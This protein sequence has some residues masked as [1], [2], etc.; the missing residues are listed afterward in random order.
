M[1]LRFVW[2]I[3]VALI[4]AHRA[5][6][7]PESAV[8]TFR[9]ANESATR[10]RFDEA[11]LV[12]ARLAQEGVRAPSLYWNWAQVASASGK[13]GTA[14]WAFMRAQELTPTDSVLVREIER[15][16]SEL[17][18]DPSELS[19]GFLGD[20]RTF[21]RRFRFD[22]LAMVAFLLSL[23]TVVRRKP[24]SALSL[25]AFVIG[26]LL[27]AP[28]LAGIWRDPRA[29][30]VHKD[31]PLMDA[32]RG[33]AL[34]LANLREGEVVPILGEENEYV[35]IQDASGARGFAHKTDVVKIEPQ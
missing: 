29:V 23:A 12:Y 35:R 10:A 25:V 18:L 17:G 32:P 5:A 9:H 30:I 3:L 19:L 13:K 21:A 6:A 8:A 20:A 34:A 15:L 24:G 2:S 1:R 4:L 16:R 28:L 26:L 27:L 7:Q 14:L 33:D 11:L 31:A 22:V